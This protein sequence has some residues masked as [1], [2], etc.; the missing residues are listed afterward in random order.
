VGV[1]KHEAALALRDA[2]PALA[3]L[4]RGR[5][6]GRG[7]ANLVRVFDKADASGYGPAKTG[8]RALT[9]KDFADRRAAQPWL[10]LA[11]LVL[12]I[13]AL[14]L[15]VN[16]LFRY[17]LL[18][19]AT[20]LV[21]A[22][23]VAARLAPWLGAIIA[24][25]LC[26]L[27]HILF[28]APRIE[29]GHNVFLVDRAGS[30]LE[31]GLPREAFR[32]MAAE[33]DATYPPARRCAPAQDGCWRA[34]G[35]PT[36]AFAFSA[37]GILDHPAY[38][39]RVTGIDFSDPVWLRLSFINEFAYNWDSQVSDLARASRDRRSLAFLRQWTLTMPWFVMYRF[40][41]DFVGSALCWRG[42][43][44]WEGA[45]ETFAPVTHADMQ[46]R[47]LTSDDIGR[48]MFGVAIARDLA[49]RLNPTWQ[50]RLRQLVEPGLALIASAIALALV[51]RVRA[52]RLVLPFAL[53]GATLLVALFNDAT[54]I[55]G[56]R[57]FDSGDDGLVYD[58]Y[59]RVI[60]RR[61]VAGDL[62]GALQGGE[63]VFYF[64]PGMRYL[65]AAEHLVFGETYL[66]Y[67]SLI[68]LLPFLVFA[69]AR[70]FLPLTW[71]IALTLIFAA[72]PVGV[73]FGS[74]LLQ[75]VKWA[76][77]G[78]ADPAAYVL[79][80]SAFVLLLVPRTRSAP[81]PLVGRGWGWGS[82]SVDP[83]RA[84]TTTPTPPTFAALR[85]ATLPARGRVGPSASRDDSAAHVSA[86]DNAPRDRFTRAFGAGLLFALALT[87]RPN[88]A[89]AAGILLAGAGLM[90][91]AERQY[92]CVAG[93]VLGFAA[94][95]GMALHN[96]V[97]GGA[98]VLF[99]TSASHPVLLT[100]PPSAYLAAL[101]ELAHLDF[102]EHVTRALRQI[103]GWLAGPSELVAM[104]PLN[105]AAIIIL[106]RVMLW[107]AAE[108][109]LRLT[110][111]ATLMQHGVA[112]FYAGSG[113][114]YYLTWL[115]TLLVVAA[116]VY[117]EGLD[118]LRRRFPN[119]TQRVAKHPARLALA[120][121]LH[122]MAAM[123]ER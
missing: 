75:Y 55:G 29:E 37:D 113:R 38:S 89:P 51:V 94:V 63:A 44:L 98:L 103:G 71:A 57:P 77:R 52:R 72:I 104:A 116:W 15:P 10:K 9:E 50:L 59:A 115:L 43:V 20:V 110:A 4:G 81:L 53:I 12:L 86:L 69:L 25:A 54:F 64:T 118:L 30:A 45:G 80:L 90:A 122:R 62:A 32:I 42:E 93:L 28:P 5:S 78:F 49:M 73:G 87:V 7:R 16:D 6:S 39:R 22:G 99:T 70:R 100:M 101:A 14:G 79:F 3:S 41:A 111:A 84:I 95:L 31:A 58:G 17:A 35:F 33:F 40:P 48:R 46:C 67:L 1:S 88:I 47:T 82:E 13:A 92:R 34:Q 120:R 61:L 117:G 114:Y 83:P 121:A 119:F 74:S 56:V 2:P 66:G 19:V 108:A 36:H 109:W 11:A 97:Y 65:R 105:A 123:V 26:V 21:V 85:R 24:V 27:G 60:L 91:L 106:V 112:L 18:V 23:T 102:G 76:A 107:K 68:L 8:R 96:W